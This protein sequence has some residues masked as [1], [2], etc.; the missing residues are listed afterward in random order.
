[1]RGLKIT[2]KKSAP[3]GAKTNALPPAPE[4]TTLGKNRVGQDVSYRPGYQ[5]KENSRASIGFKKF[6]VAEG[7]TS[8][9]K[10]GMKNVGKVS[11][12]NK[13]IYKVGE[14]RDALNKSG[15]SYD[16]KFDKLSIKRAKLV[17]KKNKYIV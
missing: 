8:L 16:K 6:G 15:K 3:M 5:P 14:K 7:P 4:G 10:E 9:N 13:K 2:K 11:R 12:L 1:M 17:T